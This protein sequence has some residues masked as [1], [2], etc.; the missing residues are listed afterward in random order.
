MSAVIGDRALAVLPAGEVVRKDRVVRLIGVELV[1]LVLTQK[2]AIPL[3]GAQIQ[4]SL[5]VHICFLGVMWWNGLL[6]VSPFQ[7]ML[8]CLTAGLALLLHT[9]ITTYGYSVPSLLSYLLIYSITIFVVPIDEGQYHRILKIY[10]K[11]AVFACLAVWLDWAVQIANLPMP[12]Y[13]ILIPKSIRLADYV[14]LQ[15]VVWGSRWSKPNGIIFPETSFVSGFL[16]VALVIEIGIFRRL[17]YIVL[18]LTS[19]LASLGGSGMLLVGLC[20]PFLLRGLRPAFIASVAVALAISLAVGAQ[21]GVFDT[22]TQRSTE[23]MNENSSGYHR[24]VEPLNLM[25]DSVLRDGPD[26]LFGAGAG[27]APK[28]LNI[29]WSP[30]A[31]AVNEYGLVFGAAF[32]ALTVSFMFGAGRP[33]II[34]WACF[35][36]YH[37]LGGGFVVPWFA[38][39][40]WMLVGGYHIGPVKRPQEA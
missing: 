38:V 17:R 25:A 6:R 36:N 13:E 18:V 28:G 11:I 3:G 24:F 30:L 21:I 7:T 37:L 12:N 1:V 20:A 39:F 9:L 32:F 33:F 15:P 40:A 29:V 27:T 10:Q 26:A 31:K 34:G 5:A 35:V 14:Y 19:L 22:L 2:L 4:I 23:V 16:G 8:Y